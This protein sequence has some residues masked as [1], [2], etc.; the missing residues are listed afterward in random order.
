MPLFR[1][2]RFYIIS[3]PLRGVFL[4]SYLKANGRSL[5]FQ[6][7]SFWKSKNDEKIPI[8]PSFLPAEKGKDISFNRIK[9]D[10]IFEGCI[11]KD[12]EG[13]VNIA[14]GEGIRIRGFEKKE[15]L[16]E[17]FRR[18]FGEKN[19]LETCFSISE[20][21]RNFYLQGKKDKARE[22]W[23][24]LKEFLK[25]LKE[26]EKAIVKIIFCLWTFI[27]H[28]F[29]QKV[30]ENG[31]F[32]FLAGFQTLKQIASPER[33]WS[34]I[35]TLFN[36]YQLNKPSDSQLL[37][38]SFL[39]DEERGLTIKKK[40]YLIRCQTSQIPEEMKN[41]VI[42]VESPLREP[43]YIERL[44]TSTPEKSSF[45]IFSDVNSSE[46]DVKKSIKTLAPLLEQPI[47]L[48][49]FGEEDFLYFSDFIPKKVIPLI[50]SIPSDISSDL[51]FMERDIER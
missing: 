42:Y 49:H 29:E 34:K 28:R 37:Q 14:I 50:P 25:K 30:A 36:F 23:E 22:K 8:F 18:E 43:L 20:E 2:E 5:S 17:E 10:E 39:P 15:I 35:I 47:D 38:P 7:P 32:P 21:M 41:P 9:I 1:K 6:A 16:L 13:Y 26:E 51:L 27:T 45:L 4:S 46:E 19:F 24:N 31:A 48:S 33:L 3:E 11:S 40:L 44:P 12:Y